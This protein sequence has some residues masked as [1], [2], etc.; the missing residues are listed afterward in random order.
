MVVVAVVAME[1]VTQARSLARRWPFPPRA[2]AARRRWLPTAPAAA[3][4]SGSFFVNAEVEPFVAV[5][6][7]NPNHLVATWQQDR[8]T[9]GGARA[10]MTAASFDG[11]RS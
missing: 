5:D 10:L 9:N 4:G 3:V 1:A 8:W 11:G 7:R 6:P 2:P